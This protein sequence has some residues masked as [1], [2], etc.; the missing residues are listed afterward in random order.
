MR[1]SQRVVYSPLFLLI[2]SNFSVL[3]EDTNS[4]FHR[5]WPDN[6]FAAEFV[7]D[8]TGYIAGY[9][10]TFLRTRDGGQNW[11][12]LYIG[13]NE[14]IRRISFVDE[15]TGWAVG[16]R[17]SIFHTAD[18]GESWAIQKELSGIYLRDVDFVDKNTGWV[19]GHN[20]SIWH[21][22]DGGHSWQQQHL[23]GFEGRD[24]PRLHGVFAKDKE[25]AILVGEFGVIG[26]T[27]NGGEFWL[28]TPNKS[29][30]TW[31]S[32]AGSNDVTYVVGLDGNM[33]RLDI[34][35][36][37]ERKIIA[38]DLEKQRARKEK[39]ARAKAKR[40]RKEYIE[41]EKLDLPHS[42]IEYSVTI[43]ESNTSEN[44]FDVSMAATGE[45]IV[46]G[47]ST[48]LKISGS[49][50][51]MFSVDE[52][53]PLPYIWFG[54]VAVTPGGNIWAPGIRGLVA[55]GKL[56]DMTFA[57]AFNLAASDKVKLLSSRWDKEK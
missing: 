23:L 6:L 39:R 36:E 15:N 53:L 38:M 21:T 26:H 35:S 22:R 40:M 56:S 45:A 32:V 57:P 13:R 55:A 28:V 29:S 44:L 1:L 12:A 51:S 34:A 9:S 30:T 47:K 43:V 16:H 54:G 11:D 4:S 48:V 42:D 10:G 49:N 20:T 37:E 19:V 25:N 52:K 7:T 41:K 18:G 27:E 2:F 50:I 14:L 5:F 8:D 24:P 46:V 31:L 33:A 17:G 3:A